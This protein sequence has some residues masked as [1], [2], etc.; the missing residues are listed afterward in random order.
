MLLNKVFFKFQELR[1]AIFE[2]LKP[3][4]KKLVVC[5]RSDLEDFKKLNRINESSKLD[6]SEHV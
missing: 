5:L 2:E 1:L 6:L 3:I 4:K